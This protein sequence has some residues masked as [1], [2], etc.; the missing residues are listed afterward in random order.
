MTVFAALSDETRVGLLEL[1]RDGEK[2]VGDL[3]GAFHLTQPAISQ[4][5]RVLKEAGL[6]SSRA[7]AQR[8][9]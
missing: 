6:V 2:S 5:L 9:V 4:H 8:R 3:V 7:Q 1:L